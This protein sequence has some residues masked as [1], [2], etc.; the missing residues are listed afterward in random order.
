MGDV[1]GEAQCQERDPLRVLEEKD[2]VAKWID[3]L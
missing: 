1:A 3:F 2:R